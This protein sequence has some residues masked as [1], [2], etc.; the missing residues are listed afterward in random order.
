MAVE[1]HAERGVGLE[2]GWRGLE[3]WREAG[4]R[5]GGRELAAAGA[6]LAGG[7]S[8]LALAPAGGR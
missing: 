3:G 4:T 8:R 2:A 1:R 6:G 7:A 5:T